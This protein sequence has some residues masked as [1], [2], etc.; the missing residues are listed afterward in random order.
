MLPKHAESGTAGIPRRAFNNPRALESLGSSNLANRF[1]LGS[2]GQ[3][4]ARN[5]TKWENSGFKAV[6]GFS[7]DISTPEARQVRSNAIGATSVIA[8]RASKEVSQLK[9]S[10]KQNDLPNA[11]AAL[12]RFGRSIQEFERK[13]TEG[14]RAVAD[15]RTVGDP[16]NPKFVSEYNRRQIFTAKAMR[17]DYDKLNTQIGNRDGL[18]TYL[19][20][21]NYSY[22]SITNG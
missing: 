19:P 1:I 12:E 21:M 14:S 2:G 10:L 17:K 4:L 15:A 7:S 5:N 6:G 16:N 3:T 9:R 20:P 13:A 18:T 11:R 8:D 22:T